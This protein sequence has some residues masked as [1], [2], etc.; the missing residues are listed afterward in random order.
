MA[1][2]GQAKFW[3]LM[4]RHIDSL[5]TGVNMLIA[6]KIHFNATLWL[7]PVATVFTVL[8]LDTEYKQVKKAQL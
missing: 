5:V 8:V 6:L 1:C 4:C 7:F 2:S 3:I